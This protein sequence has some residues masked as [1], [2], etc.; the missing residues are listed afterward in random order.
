[1]AMGLLYSRMKSFHFKEKIDSLP[2]KV[3]KILP[4]LHIRIK[5]TN[6]CNHNCYYCAYRQDNLQLG[7]DMVVRDSISQEKM[8]EIIDDMEQ[9]QV[10][11]VTFSGGGEPLC[12]PFL[13]ESVKRLSKVG[14][15]FATLT[16]GGYLKD[17]IAE[18]FVN[19][20]S[21]IRISIDGWDDESYSSYRGVP[22]G[23]FTKV[24]EN[25]RNFKKQNGK[26]LLGIVIIT[27]KDNSLHIYELIKRLKDAGIDSVKIAPCL[28]SN[29]GEES[30]RYHKPIFNAVKEQILRA[31]NELACEGFE[32]FDSYHEQLEAF[33]KDYSWCPYLQINPVIGADLNVYPCHDKAYNID[34]GLLGSI[35][36]MRF[37]DFWFS[38]KRNF[39]KI[40]PSRHCNH[41]CMVN[42]K[43]RFI[44]EYLDTDKEHLEFV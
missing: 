26:C 23:E 29:S 25:I 5:P 44:L 21:W 1:M 18:F 10:K 30:N 35:K 36:E 8:M 41:H 19:Y 20:G 31:M 17:E 38:N 33:K 13:L 15:K 40:D 22:K 24:M 32:I 7:K 28:I 3:D 2:K 27:D 11:A 43:N 42:E 6:V 37:K 9:M 16:H 39:F 12:Y 34:E 14:I 4:P